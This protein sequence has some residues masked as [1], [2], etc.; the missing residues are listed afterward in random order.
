MIR[1]GDYG[2]GVVVL[3]LT[4]GTQHEVYR[5]DTQ[6]I[7]GIHRVRW[8][9]CQRARRRLGFE[10]ALRLKGE[11]V[12]CTRNNHAEG[13]FNGALGVLTAGTVP[14]V[15]APRMVTMQVPLEDERKG[16]DSLVCHL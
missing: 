8:T 5:P 3:P 14:A 12:I 1:L 15:E 13:L 6:T 10:G 16:R 4:V 7:C 11:R 2:T 9:I